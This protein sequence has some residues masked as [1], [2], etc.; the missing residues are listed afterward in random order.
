MKFYTHIALLALMLCTTAL[1]FA[2]TTL[3]M[4]VELPGIAADAKALN[5]TSGSEWVFRAAPTTVLGKTY[6]SYAYVSRTYIQYV[7]FNINKSTDTL[8]TDIAYA[9][10]SVGSTGKVVIELEG[11]I[12]KTMSLKQGEAPQHL[13]IP[14]AGKSTLRITP[15]DDKI[16]F[17][18]PRLLPGTPIAVAPTAVVNPVPIADPLVDKL[19]A[20][21]I[22]MRATALAQN[23][24]VYADSLEK[25]LLDMGVKL[26]TTA[27]GATTW[28]RVEIPAAMVPVKTPPVVPAIPP[29]VP[30]VPPAPAK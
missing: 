5:K 26:T 25:S 3:P 6:E 24:K 12:F 13:E 2:Q 7:Y 11:S 19:V 16:L 1:V 22:Q 15:S 30:P 21:I 28:G 18:N 27:D 10:T 8:S 23:N 9:D 20:L 17:L 4:P 14:F 29:T